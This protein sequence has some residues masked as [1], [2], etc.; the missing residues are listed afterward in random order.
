MRRYWII[1]VRFRKCCVFILSTP[2]ELSY[3]KCNSMTPFPAFWWQKPRY[4]EFGPLFQKTWMPHNP[5]AIEECI[6][7]EKYSIR[8]N[9]LDEHWNQSPT[10]KRTPL[11]CD[12]FKLP[13]RRNGFFFPGQWKK[14]FSTFFLRFNFL[15]YFITSHKKSCE[16]G[17]KLS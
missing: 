17:W 7:A 5:N 11:Q 10:T 16:T 2:P 12:H 3:W 14:L 13:S 8:S 1:T 4:T 15:L 6:R 9:E